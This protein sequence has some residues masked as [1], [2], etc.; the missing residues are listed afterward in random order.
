MA[1]V[2][3]KNAWKDMQG[4]VLL[5]LTSAAGDTKRREIQ[6]WSRTN[7]R[8]E[9]SMLMRFVQPADVRGT[10]FLTIE[11]QG[12]DD[13]RRLFLPSLRR[14]NRI[15]TSGAGGNFMSSD[16]TYYDIGM[17]KLEDWSYSSAGEAT[18]AGVACRL[19]AGAPASPR[20]Q[21]DTGYTKVVW[22]VDPARA[23]V[24]GADYYE[25]GG[26][27]FKVLEVLAVEDIKGTPFATHMR[28]T[29]Q[30][31]GHRSELVFKNLKTDTGIADDVFTE[32]NLIR[33]TR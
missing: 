19:V 17:P 24:V 3:E 11:H 15:S 31:T 10:G 7:A 14:V 1:R 8:D 27:R 21:A 30:T 26:R 4:E 16:F 32:R 18:R 22:C 9:N 29:D 28:M 25:K 5:T 13:D 6:M 20:V 12:G 2:L 23:L 33:W